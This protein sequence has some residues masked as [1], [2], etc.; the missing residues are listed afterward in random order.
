MKR[1]THELYQHAVK[2]VEILRKRL[3]KLYAHILRVNNDTLT[4]ETLND[5]YSKLKHTS[6]RRHKQHGK[7]VD[8][9]SEH[10]MDKS[11]ARSDE[12]WQR[13]AREDEENLVEDESKRIMS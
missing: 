10:C 1:R 4:K 11:S 7:G 9:R 3:F 8:L 5:S 2:I 6:R 12:T 13:N